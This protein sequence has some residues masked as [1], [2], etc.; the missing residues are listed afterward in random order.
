MMTGRSRTGS[1]ATWMYEVWWED[2]VIAYNDET[3]A[4]IVRMNDFDTNGATSHP[5]ASRF[6]LE[7][8]VRR[9]LRRPRIPRS[10]LYT[11]QTQ[12]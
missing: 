10:Q 4:V 2:M 1:A 9:L 7:R 11:P 8:H 12:S 3:S 6:G 5:S